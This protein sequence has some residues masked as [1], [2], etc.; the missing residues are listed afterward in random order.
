MD[1]KYENQPIIRRL[2][3]PVRHALRK[4]GRDVRDARRR[5]TGWAISPAP[6]ERS[7]G[8]AARRRKPA[9]AHSRGAQAETHERQV[10]DKEALVFVDLDG[11]PH[12][13]GQSVGPYAL[14]QGKRRLRIRQDMACLILSGARPAG[15]S[16]PVSHSGRHAHLR[17]HRRLHARPLLSAM[18][19]LGSKDNE[20]RNETSK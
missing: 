18:S 8:P 17:S 10:M 3:P 1:I 9:T 7:R 16:R 5:R 20:T 4:L 13:M 2:P 15:W 12:L 19:L 11:V 14:E 6:K